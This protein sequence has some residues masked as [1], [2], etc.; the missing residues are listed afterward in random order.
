MRGRRHALPGD[1][2]DAATA[3]AA[4]GDQR[5][6]D[7]PAIGRERALHDREVASLDRVGAE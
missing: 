4:V 5:K 2:G 7:L 1:R 3:V 6:V